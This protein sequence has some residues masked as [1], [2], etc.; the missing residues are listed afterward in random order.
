MSSINSMT[1]FGRIEV[2]LPEGRLQWEMRSVN[3]RYLD[4]QMKLPEGFRI[5][6]QDLNQLVAASIGRGKVDAALTINKKPGQAASTKLNSAVSQQVIG[7]LETLKEQMKNAAPIS[8]EA[9]L[10]WPGVLEEEEINPE[11]VF[12]AAREALESAIAELAANRAREGKKIQEML[13]RRCLEIESAVESVRQRLPEV[14][15]EIRKRLTQRI[16]TLNAQLDN[17]RLEQEILILAQKLDVS[18]ELDRIKAHLHEVRST[19]EKKEPVGRR[20]DFLMQ[21]LNREANTLASKSADAE[22]TRQAVDL[23]VLV[24]QM[25]EQVQNVE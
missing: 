3:H 8:A 21:E 16:E 5:F 14:L 6:E 11:S 20:L 25:R 7:H 15:V 18:E 22:T 19:F 23:K 12:P 24:E 13:E 17:D 2:Q 9:V 4:I 10:R 1:G